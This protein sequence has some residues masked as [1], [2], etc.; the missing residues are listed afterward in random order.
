L[1]IVHEIPGNHP[2]ALSARFKR[3][4]EVCRPHLG[5]GIVGDY[6]PERFQE[7]AMAVSGA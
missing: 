5:R 3:L 4:H 7:P 1:R 6:P 2:L